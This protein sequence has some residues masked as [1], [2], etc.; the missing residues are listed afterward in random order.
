MP[1]GLQ[2]WDTSGNSIFDVTTGLI[3]F[4]GTVTVGKDY[5]GA[6]TSGTV[7]DSRFTSYTAHTAFFANITST[8]DQDYS[9]V[10]IVISGNTLTWTY[11]NPTPEYS[12]GV[13]I[14]RPN[15]FIVYG[16]Y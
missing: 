12:G 5:T 11:P 15:A 4:L 9:E 2:I 10:E 3:K 1:Q 7:T 13:L 14:N 8:P 16:I 6:T